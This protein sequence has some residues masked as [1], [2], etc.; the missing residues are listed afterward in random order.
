MVVFIVRFTAS[1]CLADTIVLKSGKTVEAKIVEKTDKEIKVDVQGVPVTYWMDEIEK[2]N[3]KGVGLAGPAVTQKED[4]P[5]ANELYQKAKSSKI[6]SIDLIHASSG[7]IDENIQA[8]L[9]KNEESIS[10]FKKAFQQKSDDIV[11]GKMDQ[12]M[13]HP[14]YFDDMNFYGLILAQTYQYIS[15][16]QFANAEE[17]LLTDVKFLKHLSEEK[18]GLYSN[19]IRNTCFDLILPLITKAVKSNS[20]SRQFYQ[21][22]LE[23]FSVLSSKD[24][25]Q[26]LAEDKERVLKQIKSLLEEEAKKEKNYGPDFWSEI[27]KDF[28]SRYP[29]LYKSQLE[30]FI[31]N[32]PEIYEQK[33]K[34]IKD[35]DPLKDK[36]PPESPEDMMKYILVASGGDAALASSL[37]LS[38]NAHPTKA[39]NYYYVGSSKINI[40]MTAIAIKL[41]QLDNNK[42]PQSLD[43]LVPKYLSKIPDDPFNN[44]APLQYKKT[45]KGYM[46]YSLGP[47]RIDQ[48]GQV[49]YDSSPGAKDTS[50]DIVF[51]FEQ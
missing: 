35:D 51:S 19:I 48:S 6:S 10:L 45:E 3:G 13:G 1:N 30:A 27:Y 42:L 21:N 28:E 33:L 11:L 44:L 9:S 32:K 2:V 23:Q 39:I 18:F 38:R 31:K 4:S 15:N 5:S 24:I 29:E 43:E 40:F 17:N 20:L 14:M 37:L 25:L 46:L 8:E 16:G 26:V 7:I 36:F 49:L 50:G 22:F 12:E 34:G 47:D 41:F